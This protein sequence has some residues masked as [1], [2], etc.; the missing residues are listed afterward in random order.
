LDQS[1][2]LV[3]EQALVTLRNLFVLL[4]VQEFFERAEVLVKLTL[5]LPMRIGKLQ[6]VSITD[7]GERE[8]SV[9]FID[10]LFDERGTLLAHNIEEVELEV[11]LIRLLDVFYQ[12]ALNEFAD[13][14]VF[15]Q[16]EIKGSFLDLKHVN[17]L[18][19]AFFDVFSQ[20]N[21]RFLL[22]YLNSHQLEEPKEGVIL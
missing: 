12:I 21:M 11:T 20:V 6:L 14:L 7:L 19:Q 8:V 10:G 15:G 2:L 1:K 3:L 18:S 9:D 16:V 4:Q 22:R 5:D 17:Q 13:S